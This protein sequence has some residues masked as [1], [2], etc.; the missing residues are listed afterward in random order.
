MNTLLDRLEQKAHAVAQFASSDDAIFAAVV[1]LVF[2]LTKRIASAIVGGVL[3]RILDAENKG[4]GTEVSAALHRPIGALWI[5]LGLFIAFELVRDSE[6]G[7]LVQ[8][9]QRLI[10]TLAILIAYWAIFALVSPLIAR[11]EP[12]KRYVTASMADWADKILKSFIVFFA[13]AAVLEQ[14]GVRVSPI[15]TSLGIVGAAV[16]LGAQS[17]FKNLIA[18][19]LILAG[20]RF[21]YGDWVKVADV[22][23]GHIETI[24]FRTTRIRQFDDSV[25]QVPNVELSDKA[26]VNV[27]QKRRWR[28]KWV[29][30]VPYS[31]TTGQLKTIRDNIEA[32]VLATAEFVRPEKAST[33]IRVDS[34]GGSSINILIYCFVET[35]NWG[36]WLQVKETLAYKVMD[37]VRDA[38]SSF[39]FPSTSLYVETLPGDRPDLFLPPQDGKPRIEPSGRT[40]G[41]ATAP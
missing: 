30:G 10:G 32:Y 27:T 20:Q 5:V 31:T 40:P 7:S 21:Q 1:L 28:I 16:A 2:V 19:I 25:V 37:I 12:T 34:F 11:I 4:V 23:E 9:S 29:I 24:G 13:L 6:G 33:F 17:F 3:R 41:D 15:L 8:L 14:W 26:V 22:A 39:A 18:G 35:V 38:G 36:H